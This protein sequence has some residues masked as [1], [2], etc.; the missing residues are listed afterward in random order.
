MGVVNTTPDSFSDG[1]DLP[2]A[3][4][5]VRHGLDLAAQGASIIDVGGEST[6]PGAGRVEPAEEQRRV[7]PVVEALV[8]HGVAVSVDTMRASTAS[9]AVRAGASIVNDVS[10]GLADPDMLRVVAEAGVDC[11]L[12]HWR[13][14]SATMQSEAHYDDVVADVIRELLSRRRAAVAGGVPPERIILDPGIGFSKKGEHNWMVLRA[15]PRFTHLGHR[16]LVG[17]SRK[18]FLG[19]LLGG[20]PATG[21]DAATAAVSAWCAQHDVWGVRTH[22][23][24]L[25]KDAILVGSRLGTRGLSERPR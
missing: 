4:L 21:R 13:G 16:L 6:R 2:T 23:V 10:G 20:R 15:I 24:A 8:S 11:V 1:G 7:L 22:E 19:D 9:A 25:Q 12:M 5:A 17:V 14:H 18:R 3:E